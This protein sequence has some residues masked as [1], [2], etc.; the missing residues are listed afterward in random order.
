MSV[1]AVPMPVPP[2][3]PREQA[4]QELALEEAAR[5]A[6][7]GY[8]GLHVDLSAPSWRQILLGGGR[9]D[10]RT[11]QFPHESLELLDQDPQPTPGDPGAKL[12][13]KLLVGL[14]ADRPR[15]MT[16]RSLSP[17]APRPP[18]RDAL[19]SWTRRVWLVAAGPEALRLLV[20]AG[21]L[22][23]SD[24]E[25]IEAAYPRGLDV[26]REGAVQAAGAL[27]TAAQR[28]GTE[29]DLQPWL[30]DQLMT[31]MDEHR[32]ADFFAAVYDGEG[33]GEPEEG[34]SSAP[35]PTASAPPSN[36]VDQTRPATAPEGR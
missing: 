34:D 18:A 28:N 2:V 17:R 32:P 7:W 35:G 31:L 33:K 6:L 27:T 12:A 20:A 36:V 16:P 1:A 19:S 21:Y 5:L 24:V 26:E 13:K 15:G 10:F 14:K 25:T 22:T 3:N 8:L 9:I 4:R 11:P 23:P 30:N 29:P